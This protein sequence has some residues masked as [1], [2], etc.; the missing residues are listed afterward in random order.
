MSHK[1]KGQLTVSGEWAKHLRPFLRRAFWKGERQAAKEMASKEQLATTPTR[2]ESGTVEEL[3]SQ[4]RSLP[5]AAAG[6]ELWVPEHLTLQGERVPLEIAMA[7]V[8]D[9][10]LD[11]GLEPEGYH[12]A[13]TGRL[14]KYK[15]QS[16]A[17]PSDA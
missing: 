9:H 1:R 16:P 3:I 4:I 10:A 7:A 13:P 11:R 2:P 17:Q 5:A 14:Y 15:V 6:L 8:L 12:S